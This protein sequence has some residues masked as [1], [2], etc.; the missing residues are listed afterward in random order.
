MLNTSINIIFVLSLL[1]TIIG[2]R[3]NNRIVHY[4]FKPMTM[5][6]LIAGALW[7]AVP[8]T[9]FGYWMLAGLCISVIGDIFMMLPND[10]FV[11]G[12]SAFLVTH[13]AYLIAF[14]QLY[15]GGMTLFWLLGVGL[16]AIAFFVLLLPNLGELKLPV[17]IYITVIC[18]MIWLAGELYFQQDSNTHLL[19]F[20]AA[21]VFAFSDAT[22]AWARF[23]Q[24]FFWSQAQVFITY[25]SAQ[26]L[27][28]I[29]LLSVT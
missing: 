21:V 15:D 8:E 7:L 10:K 5:L 4:I 17:A 14:Y 27:F 2:D 25:F 24:P 9:P 6:V 20:A 29:A 28:V 22:I 1:L 11:Q 13:V 23:R 18:A 16:F 3:F 26:W 12:L 19:L